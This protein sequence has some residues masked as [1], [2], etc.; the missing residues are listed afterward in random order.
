MSVALDSKSASEACPPLEEEPPAPPAD[1]FSTTSRIDVGRRSSSSQGRSHEAEEQQQWPSPTVLV[2]PS[3]DLG[4]TL[5]PVRGR[6]EG[7]G[8]SP[9]LFRH[10]VRVDLGSARTRI[11]VAAAMGKREQQWRLG[12]GFVCGWRRWR[13]RRRGA[14]IIDLDRG[15]GLGWVADLER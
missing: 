3:R 10:A 13:Q 12:E 5:G 9:A 11:W 1:G 7:E 8:G 2:I 4:A 14:V 6:G 15:E